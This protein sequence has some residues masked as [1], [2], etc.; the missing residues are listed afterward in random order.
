MNSNS[1]EN[2]MQIAS[3]LVILAVVFGV[4]KYMGVFNGGKEGD[5][6]VEYRVEGSTAAAVVTYTQADGTPTGPL[7]VTLPWKKKVSFSVPTTAI[8]TAGNPSQTGSIKCLISLNGEA[9]KQEAVT[10][11]KDKVSCAGI[12]P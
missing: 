2:L 9:W 4:L 10:A 5:S 7:D 8:L 1:K 12:V 11:P 6:V 3:V